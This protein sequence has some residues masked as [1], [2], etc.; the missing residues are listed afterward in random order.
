M[1]RRAVCQFALLPLMLPIIGCGREGES[2]EPNFATD[3][4]DDTVTFG[5]LP[6]HNPDFLHRI[7]TP[8]VD[9]LNATAGATFRLVASR[10][11][12]TFERRL[13]QGAFDFAL[14]NPYQAIRAAAAGY[15]IFGKVSRDEDFCGLILTRRATPIRSI[16]DL[17]GK[18]ISY[19]APT[20]VAAAMMSQ[21]YLHRHGVA[22]NATRPIYVGS[23]ESAIESV[24]IGASDAGSIWP[25]PWLKYQRSKPR[26]A[27]LLEVRWRTPH[28][29]NNA[30]LVRDTIPAAVSNRVIAALSRLRASA[31][32]QRLL[33]QAMFAG[34]EG[35][36]DRTYDPVRRFLRDFSRTVRPLE[37]TR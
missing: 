9:Y 2:Y 20:A 17:R 8:L 15:R 28:L 1:H 31:P 30:L 18:T 7:Y 12:A 33:A 32:G 27:R 23:M 3:G 24:V 35:A 22:L 14:S 19:P 37:L 29:V 5:I 4:R 11:Y 6:Q 26:Q 16:T 21:Y 10:D 36:D 25:D 13:E 34:F